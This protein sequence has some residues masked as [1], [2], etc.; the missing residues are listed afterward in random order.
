VAFRV[1]PPDLDPAVIERFK[2]EPRQAER[3]LTREFASEVTAGLMPLKDFSK[4][5]ALRCV[6][7]D[8]VTGLAF[9]LPE[10]T[11]VPKEIKESQHLW[12]VITTDQYKLQFIAPNVKFGSYDLV[13]SDFPL[14]VI[15]IQRRESFRVPP[16]NDR[17]LDLVISGSFS[18]VVQPKIF[19][20]GF[21]GIG[22]EFSAMERIQV[23]TIWSN[24]YFARG[25]KSSEKFMLQ[26]M[27]VSEVYNLDHFRVGC[28][29]LKPTEQNLT[30]F[31][32]TRNSIQNARVS[33]QPQR[34]HLSVS[35]L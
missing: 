9:S 15:A 10:G 2:L 28:Q 8:S 23:G 13:T 6:E 32:T 26:V 18:A 3:T 21:H 31:E 5:L 19:D 29:L 4:K 22:L 14:E 20:I 34:W 12:V 7:A 25:K 33:G 16:P 24:A 35:W 1:Y 27:N 30:D 17:T 11:D